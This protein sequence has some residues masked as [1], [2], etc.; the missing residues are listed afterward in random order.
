MWPKSSA[1]GYYP[2]GL[3]TD[4]KIIALSFD[5]GPSEPYTADMLAV[6]AKHGVPGTFFLVGKNVEKNPELARRIIATGQTIGNHAYSHQLGKYLSSPSLKDE[7]ELTQ[8]IIFKVTGKKPAYFRSPWLI[9]NPGMFRVLAANKMTPISGIFGTQKE[10]YLV[11]AKKIF[12]DAC[13]NLKPGQ[14]MVFHDGINKNGNRS[15]TVKAIDL[16]IP[17]LKRRGYEIVSVEA[18][19]GI[20][21]YQ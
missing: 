19:L 5:D 3:K 7:I 8:E 20:P 16:F 14:I 13:S 4:K 12:N 18:L 6:L 9:R 11:P 2:Y 15:E 10:V 17:E 21:A 1:F